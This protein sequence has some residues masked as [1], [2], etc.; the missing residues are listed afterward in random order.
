[1][2]ATYARQRPED[3]LTRVGHRVKSAEAALRR[4][5]NMKAHEVE[6]RNEALPRAKS[7]VAIYYQGKQVGV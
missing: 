5:A 1:M 6:V 2:Y 4:A 7:L 3:L